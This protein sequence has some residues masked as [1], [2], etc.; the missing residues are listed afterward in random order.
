MFLSTK[1]D[2]RLSLIRH[3]R[4]PWPQI[5]T[6]GCRPAA[7]STLL[8]PPCGPRT[9]S[10]PLSLILT[11]PWRLAVLVGPPRLR[12]NPK[13]TSLCFQGAVAFP[14]WRTASA[15]IAWPR[16]A[17]PSTVPPLGGQG[18]TLTRR[19]TIAPSPQRCPTYTLVWAVVAQKHRADRI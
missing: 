13:K 14:Q 15:L 3:H 18:G 19:G 5:S 12:H 8:L 11:P 2:G 7:L 10:R 17:S 1:L 4:A 6:S 9:L 16:H